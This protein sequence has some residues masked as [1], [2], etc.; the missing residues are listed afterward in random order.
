[1]GRVRTQIGVNSAVVV[2]WRT[3]NTAYVKGLNRLGVPELSRET[4]TVEEFG[5]D[6]SYEIATGYKQG[7]FTFS[8]YA[9]KGDT[10][11]QEELS[12]RLFA[13]A[14]FTDCAVMLNKEDFYGLDLARD[15]DGYFQVSKTTSGE[16]GKNDLYPFSGEII[17]AGLISK[18]T[19]H[20]C[21]D[22]VGF[23]AGSSGV[24][25]TV[26]DS[27]DGF[28]EAGFRVGDTLIVHGSASNNGY[29]LIKEVAAGVLTLETEGE[30][31]TEAASAVI[32]LDGGRP[33]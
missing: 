18:Y 24:K 15:P 17:C 5:R 19:R 7:R 30:L 2:G 25:D 28:V 12:D 8:G 21:G 13:N 1:M 11:G 32:E 14:E 4:V 29:Y 33:S 22:T 23:T 27:G 26:T 31:T 6:S 3:S 20:L 9:I 10:L 16:V